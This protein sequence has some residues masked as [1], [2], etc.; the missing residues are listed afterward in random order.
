MTQPIKYARHKNLKRV[1]L[2]IGLVWAISAA[3]GLPIVL[4]LN[5][6]ER[7]ISTDCAFYNADFVIYSSLSSFYIPCIIMVFL[8]YQIFKVNTNSIPGLLWGAP[9]PTYFLP[10]TN[11]RGTS[12]T[13]LSDCNRRERERPCYSVRVRAPNGLCVT[14]GRHVWARCTVRAKDSRRSV[15]LPL[16]PLLRF[17]F[18][19][20]AQPTVSFSLLFLFRHRADEERVRASAT[21]QRRSAHKVT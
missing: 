15:C 4:G 5:Y 19:L 7:R 11:T 9:S 3:I 13:R 12:S 21:Q 16:Q 10:L 2:T 1:W 20:A 8:Y 18:A 17:L 6:S 14:A